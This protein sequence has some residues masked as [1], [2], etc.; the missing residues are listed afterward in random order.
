VIASHAG[1]RQSWYAEL[2]NH[3]ARTR[4]AIS[5]IPELAKYLRL[6]DFTARSYGKMALLLFGAYLSIHFA[7]GLLGL[8]SCGAAI[9][10]AFTHTQREHAAHKALA[11]HLSQ[12]AESLF[13]SRNAIFQ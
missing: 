4:T 8:A 3:D 12:L 2:I 10:C 1:T 5:P 11:T 9:Y 6:A 13:A 7:S